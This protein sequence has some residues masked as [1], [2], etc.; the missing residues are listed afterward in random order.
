MADNFN[1]T[2]NIESVSKTKKQS[3]IAAVP[4]DGTTMSPLVQPRAGAISSS[5]LNAFA[6]SVSMGIQ[7]TKTNWNNLTRPVLLSLPAGPR[8]QRWK[9]RNEIDCLTY[10]IQGSTL[11]V[12]NDATSTKLDGRYWNALESRPKTIIEALEDIHKDISNITISQEGQ[13]LVDLDPLWAAIGEAYRDS[14][15]VGSSGS[16]DIRV[17]TVES[18]FKQ[19]EAD[20]YEPTTFPYGL[21]NAL[22]YSIADN[23]DK[24]LVLHNV[25]GFGSDPEGVS[26]E[27]LPIADHI[28]SYDEIAPAINQ[29]LTKSRMETVSTLEDD[30]QRIR[31]EIFNVKGSTTWNEDVADPVTASAGDLKKHMNY[32]GSGTISTE[33]PHAVGYIETGMGP[34]IDAVVAYTGMADS[35]DS[36]PEYPSTNYIS[37][38]DSLTEA[39]GKL[40]TAIVSISESARIRIDYTYDRSEFSETEREELPIIIT[41]DQGKK[42]LVQVIDVSPQEQDY[43]GQYVSPDIWYNLVHRSDNE[44]EVWTNAAVIEVIAIF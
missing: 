27:G 36:D 4:Q 39:I 11:F 17:G 19:L 44:F 40:D 33:N 31:Y 5:D 21:G 14:G 24:L 37:D 10:G 30:I 28:H 22:P 8:D 1:W 35:E 29:T 16:L 18:Y 3:N 15:M 34:I 6:R 41:H 23:L 42:P 38:G 32:Q 9:L 20:I 13:T 12:F 26:H 25:T 2:S 7:N 43:F